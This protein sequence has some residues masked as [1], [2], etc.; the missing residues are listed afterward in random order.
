MARPK[1][2][3]NVFFT[4]K[5]EVA[6][7]AFINSSF[8]FTSTIFLAQIF[9]IIKTFLSAQTLISTFALALSLIL[10][11]KLTKNHQVYSKIITLRSKT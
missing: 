3:Y 5:N 10:K 9:T 4:S 7:K 6:R 1:I 8:I 2:C 11:Y